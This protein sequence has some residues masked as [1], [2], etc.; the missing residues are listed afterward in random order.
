MNEVLTLRKKQVREFL[1]SIRTINSLQI[2][3]EKKLHTSSSEPY[4][5]DTSY[6]MV[7]R[8]N[9]VLPID[10]QGCCV[11]NTPVTLSKKTKRAKTW[12]CN[13]SKPT[14]K[15]DKRVIENPQLIF[16]APLNRVRE[17]LNNLHM[18]CS[19]GH[20]VHLD[21]TDSIVEFQGHPLPCC[22]GG[23]FSQ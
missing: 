14:S 22:F 10:E 9:V 13:E 12:K 2:D 5:Y 7:N 20:Y 11:T 21:G 18:N 16:K 15:D 3:F 17:T 23:C 6:Q 1:R 8:S 4:F 19:H